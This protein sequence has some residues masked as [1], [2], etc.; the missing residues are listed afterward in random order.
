MGLCIFINRIL[1]VNFESCHWIF[2]GYYFFFFFFVPC[3]PQKW[4]LLASMMLRRLFVYLFFILIC[5]FFQVKLRQQREGRTRLQSSARLWGVKPLGKR[6]KWRWKKLTSRLEQINSGRA[7]KSAQE[8]FH[9]RTLYRALLMNPTSI[10]SS[11]ASCLRGDLQR[12]RKS[13]MN[14]LTF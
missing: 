9:S 12:K 14:Q 3:G 1:S 8:T 6:K 4:S 2:F 13:I 10:G 5:P 11:Q 7:N